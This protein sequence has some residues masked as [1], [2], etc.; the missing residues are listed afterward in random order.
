M[1]SVVKAA[2]VAVDLAIAY[3]AGYWIV[4]GAKKFARKASRDKEE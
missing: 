4:R 3:V 2:V 1:G